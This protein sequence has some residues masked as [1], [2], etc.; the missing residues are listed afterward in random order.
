MRHWR[1]SGTFGWLTLT[2]LC[3]VYM[4]LGR[5][6]VPYWL[7]LLQAAEDVNPRGERGQAILKRARARGLTEGHVARQSDRTL[8]TT[9]P[10]SPGPSRRRQADAVRQLAVRRAALVCD[11]SCHGSR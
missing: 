1:T 8:A 7:A 10:P 9:R 11:W 2:G 5:P 4:P 6:K 3:A